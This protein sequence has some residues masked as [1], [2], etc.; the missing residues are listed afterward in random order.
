MKSKKGEIGTENEAMDGDSLARSV[1]E[2]PKGCEH[3]ANNITK[4]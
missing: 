3:D 1:A 4:P 2:S